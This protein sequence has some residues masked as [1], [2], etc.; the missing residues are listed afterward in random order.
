MRRETKFTG[1]HMLNDPNVYGLDRLTLGQMVEKHGLVF[2]NETELH[3]WRRFV[4][5]NT[6]TEKF[7]IEK[8]NCL[9]IGGE[10]KGVFALCKDPSDWAERNYLADLAEVMI[11]HR[12]VR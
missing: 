1:R 4:V 3:K 8:A 11:L 6:E 12:E 2:R 7:L 5:Y 9:G 10:V